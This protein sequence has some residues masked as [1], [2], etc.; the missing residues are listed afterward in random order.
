MEKVL[1][2][3][4]NLSFRKLLREALHYYHPEIRIIVVADIDEL[5]YR[6]AKP[7]PTPFS[8]AIGIGILTRLSVRS[9][10]ISEG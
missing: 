4:Q 3:D 5:E 1:I 7:P 9:M 8:S 10:L 2:V 6:D